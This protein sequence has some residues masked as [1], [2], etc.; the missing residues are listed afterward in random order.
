MERVR[1]FSQGRPLTWA[2]LESFDDDGYRYEIVDG[3]LLMSPSPRPLHQRVVARLLTVLGEHCPRDLE[4]LPA[5]VDVVLAD[6]TVLIPDVVV[7]RRA[8]NRTDVVI[9]DACNLA[10]GPVATIRLPCRI[11]EGFHG[12]WLPPQAVGA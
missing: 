7:G 1:S 2:D 6:D 3:T 12:T 5:P 11:H 8:E 9:L 4:V 10:A